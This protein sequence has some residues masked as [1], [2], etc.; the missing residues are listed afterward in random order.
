MTNWFAYL[1]ECADSTLYA[2]CTNDLAARL[3]AHDAGRG[4]KYTRGRGPVRL[5]LAERLA[6]RGEAQKREAALKKLSRSAKLALASVASGGVMVARREGGKTL[7]EM[8]ARLTFFRCESSGHRPETSVSLSWDEEGIRGEF[9]V[10]DRFVTV[11]NLRPNSPV[12][13]DSCVEFFVKPSQAEGYF[14]FEWNAAGAML[15][16]YVTDPA[17]EGGGLRGMRLL[18]LSDAALVRVEP[19]LPRTALA[20]SDAPLDWRLRFFI[21]FTLLRKYAGDFSVER[22]GVWRCNFFK[23]ADGSS[24]PHWA[25]WMPLPE[26]NF[27]LPDSFGWLVFG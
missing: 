15:A 5:L 9:L 8:A 26:R 11:E 23:C 7:V 17:R 1:L 6:T 19:S 22:G 13:R 12:Y 10:A 14:N 21:P 18:E 16:G 3:D 27:H 2:G 20:E 24:Q 25:S 4:A